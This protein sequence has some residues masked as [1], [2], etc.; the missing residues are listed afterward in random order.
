MFQKSINP[1]SHTRSETRVTLHVTDQID[2]SSLFSTP[3]SSN[4]ISNMEKRYRTN[5][6]NSLSGYKSANL[7]GTVSPT[8]ISNLAIFSSVVHLGADP[9]LVGFINRPHSVERQT[10]E[11][12]YATGY[13]T[14][15]HVNESFYTAAHQTSARYAADVSE[16][17]ATGLTEQYSTLDA[18]YVAESTIKYGVK[19]LGKQEIEY[20]QTVLIIGEIIEV[21]CDQKY[22]EKDGKIDLVRAQSVAVSGLD[23]YHHTNSLGRQAYAKP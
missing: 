17:E 13:Y 8:G 11:N 12:I 6:I 9:A 16:F 14:I 15:N 20:N 22:L 3:F 7:I 21:Y 23:E 19:Y 10:L 1:R 18:P 5:F 2:A 4:D